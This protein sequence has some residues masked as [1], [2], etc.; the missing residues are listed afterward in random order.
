MSENEFAKEI[1]ELT[2]I[3]KKI[4][5]KLRKKRI[6]RRTEKILEVI[7]CIAGTL[8]LILAFYGLY[9]SLRKW[10]KYVNNKKEV[11]EVDQMSA[12]SD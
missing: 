5:A 3:D 1:F 11:T 9:L 8:A 7:N 4:K 10:E 6:E 12:L 2:G